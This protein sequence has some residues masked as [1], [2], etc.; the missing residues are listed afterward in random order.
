MTTIGEDA[1]SRAGLRAVVAAE[2]S[3]EPSR[4]PC[5]SER[6]QRGE[7]SPH[8]F[9]RKKSRGPD[10]EAATARLGRMR[11]AKKGGIFG[12]NKANMSFRISNLTQKWR[13]NKANRLNPTLS[14]T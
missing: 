13:K 6:A 14:T 9:N 4:P 10:F 2:D 8:G 12:W 5:H 7:E 1:R 3:F 11:G